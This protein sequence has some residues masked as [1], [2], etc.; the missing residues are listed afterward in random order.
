[1]L[2][3]DTLVVLDLE[4]LTLVK[5]LKFKNVGCF[6]LNQNPITED[7]FTVE[8]CI[9]TKKKILYVHL[10]TEKIKIIK[11][12]CTNLTPTTLVMDGAHV[13]FAMGSEYCMVDVFSGE[14]QELFTI[15]TPDQPPII[16]K[17]SKVSS[18]LM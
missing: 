2:F 1:M 14:I 7:P 18:V 16:Y 6:C 10:S 15:D 17:V 4:T 11:E 12:I 3:D 9:A 5:T 13:C 8:I